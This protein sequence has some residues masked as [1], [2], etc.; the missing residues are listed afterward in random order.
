ME[1]DLGNQKPGGDFL[2]GSRSYY[3]YALY[4]HFS[5]LVKVIYNYNKLEG[6]RTCRATHW[7]PKWVIL[8]VVYSFPEYVK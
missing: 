6:S 7:A 8:Q 5:P 2:T 1:H 4:I 3:I